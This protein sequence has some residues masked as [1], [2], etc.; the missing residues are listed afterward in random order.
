MTEA[1]EESRPLG[2]LLIIPVALATAA[3]LLIQAVRASWLTDDA[4][5]AFRYVDNLAAGRG[6]TF[7]AGE[8]VEGFSSLLFVLVLAPFRALGVAPASAAKVLGLGGSLVELLALVLLSFRITRSAAVALVGGAM[9][10]TDRIVTV[11]STG[12]LETSFHAGLLFLAFALTIEFRD[13]PERGIVPIALLHVCVSA[14]RPEGLAFLPLYLFALAYQLRRAGKPIVPPMLRA[15]AVAG[16]GHAVLFGGRYLYFRSL[17]PNTYRAKV[18]GVPDLATFGWGYAEQFATRLGWVDGAHALIWVALAGAVV[19]MRRTRVG[20]AKKKPPL[21]DLES[22]LVVTVAY[23]VVAFFLPIEM[24]G[25]YMND[26]RFYRPA[27]GLIYFAVA[28]ALGCVVERNTPFAKA[29]AAGIGLA[30]LV[31]HGQRQRKAV[32]IFA[33]APPSA[34][35]KEQVSASLDEAKRFTNAMLRF[36]EP[37]D[38]VIADRLG[39]MAYGHTLRAIDATGLVSPRVLQDFYLREAVSEFGKRERLPGHARW[40]S[41]PMMQREHVAIIF[42]KVNKKPP[43]MPEVGPRS[44]ARYKSYPFLHVTV[45]LGNGEFLRFLTAF[46]ADE[47]R[48]RSTQRGLPLCFRPSFGALECVGGATPEGR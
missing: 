4:L 40:P 5:I 9:L 28:C 26:F 6:L 24:G 43:S 35:H 10:A 14:S 46:S 31:S 16:A 44:P 41:V 27:M 2:E 15:F 7:N 13:R 11:W 42:P 37:T 17:V 39:V 36:A 32:A 34:P 18:E 12:G 22:I 19:W 33:D 48:A 3:V 29:L 47:L 38:S 20:T 8:R 23:V 21:S 45:P 30:L 25:D 1:T